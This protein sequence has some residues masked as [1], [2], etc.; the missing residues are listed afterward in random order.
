ML[1]YPSDTDVGE[2]EVTQLREHGEKEKAPQ[3]LRRSERI[4]K[5]NPMYVNNVTT[6]NFLLN[7]RSL[8]YTYHKH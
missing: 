8:L 3:R 5:P 4:Q 1:V 7:L 2:K 6:R